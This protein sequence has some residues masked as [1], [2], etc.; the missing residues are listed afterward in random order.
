MGTLADLPKLLPESDVVV[1]A[2][3]HNADT[4]DLVDAKFVAAMKPGSMLVNIG[5]GQLVVDEALLAGLDQNAP[6]LAILDV[7]RTEPLPKDHPFWTHAKVRVTGHTSSS[8]NG[9]LSRADNFF[10]ENLK[11]FESGQPLLS[12]V[13]I[14]Q[15]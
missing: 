4:N 9:T 1:L 5:R 12:P 8:G 7:F 11:R 6:A 3:A 15:F 10:L 2:A 13:S 14:N